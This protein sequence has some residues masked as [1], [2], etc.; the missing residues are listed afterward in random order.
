MDTAIVV[1]RDAE[2]QALKRHLALTLPGQSDPWLIRG[3]DG[4]VAFVNLAPADCADLESQELIELKRRLGS[5]IRL[6]LVVASSGHMKH[7]K[8]AV[9]SD[10]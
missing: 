7:G 10:A 4:P 2:A 5:E 3:M 9:S 8:T 1:I 6:S